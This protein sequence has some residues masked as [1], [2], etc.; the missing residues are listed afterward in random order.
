MK[1][2][3]LLKR[4]FLLRWSDLQFLVLLELGERGRAGLMDLVE[5][6]GAS[7]TGIWNALMSPTMEDFILKEYKGKR[8]SYRLTPAGKR[9]IVRALTR[10]RPPEL[11]PCPPSETLSFSRMPSGVLS[12]FS[13]RGFLC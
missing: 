10:D 2:K 6:T 3:D 11:N 7:T 12:G 9:V 13:G 4:K 8:V 1:P 5:A